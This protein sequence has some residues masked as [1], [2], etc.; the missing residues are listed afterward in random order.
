ME[1]V[2]TSKYLNSHLFST[3]A[4]E[5]EVGCVAGDGK[6]RMSVYGDWNMHIVR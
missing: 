3:F 2:R 1:Y 4:V 6:S 5:R